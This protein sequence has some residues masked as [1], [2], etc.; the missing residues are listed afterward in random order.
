MKNIK[1]LLIILTAALFFTACEKD[2]IPETFDSIS[3]ILSAGENIT[4]DDLA[5]MKIYLGRFHDSVEFSTISFKTY[6]IDSVTTTTIDADGTFA[7][8]NLLPGNYGLALEEGYIF[9]FDTALVVSLNE[10]SITQIHN[11]V[12]LYIPENHNMR[13]FIRSFKTEGLYPYSLQKMYEFDDQGEMID[14]IT[15]TADEY[16][17]SPPAKQI[18]EF[19]KYDQLGNK[20]SEI[21]LSEMMPARS[22]ANTA[23]S[24]TYYAGPIE[25][26]WSPYK[27]TGILFWKKIHYGYYLIKL[28]N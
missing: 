24:H 21:I 27:E 12:D 13:S 25:I 16:W 14:E 7:F 20:T 8:N 3:G 28:H 2:E 9:S 23:K 26:I 17:G 5:G 18:L 22:R 15:D 4:A 11:S 6:A 19:C 10:K 1:T